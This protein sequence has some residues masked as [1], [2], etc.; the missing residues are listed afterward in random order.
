MACVVSMIAVTIAAIAHMVSND[1][2]GELVQDRC[3]RCGSDLVTTRGAG[4]TAT[5]GMVTV[6]VPADMPLVRCY[7]CSTPSPT[8]AQMQEL[9][10]QMERDSLGE[11][12]RSGR[13]V[14]RGT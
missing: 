6:A 1:K 7:G 14:L 9:R 4:R 13:P 2:R 12:G 11:G 10:E 3:R 8:P 5:F